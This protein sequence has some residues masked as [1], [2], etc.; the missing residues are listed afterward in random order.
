MP[1]ADSGGA[2]DPEEREERKAFSARLKYAMSR[3]NMTEAALERA[4]GLGSWKTM[5]SEDGSRTQVFKGNGHL[6]R[7]LREERGSPG[8]ALVKKLAAPL[9]V[10][11][12]WL[13][14][15]EQPMA[16]SEVPEALNGV[17]RT[18]ETAWPNWKAASEGI[19][20]AEDTSDDIAMATVGFGETPTDQ[21]CPAGLAPESLLPYV[22][23][24]LG[25]LPPRAKRDQKQIQAWRTKA[26]AIHRAM[27]PSEKLSRKAPHPMGPKK[28]A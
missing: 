14:F 18:P 2:V 3:K 17:R 15:D 12:A 4:A 1:K 7:L 19:I 8:G 28:K 26:A 5:V 27:Y 20:G 21:P 22:D 16:A 11:P 25:A 23:A 13:L 10:R 24:F 9:G 6:N